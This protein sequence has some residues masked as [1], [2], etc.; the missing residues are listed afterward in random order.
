MPVACPGDDYGLRIEMTRMGVEPL[1]QSLFFVD[2][3]DGVVIGE[4]T[5]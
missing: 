1:H 2:I 5:G 3:F 4:S